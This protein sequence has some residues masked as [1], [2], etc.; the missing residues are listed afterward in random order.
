V[1][2]LKVWISKF[3]SLTELLP[4]CLNDN[5]IFSCSA[6][7]APDSTS[8]KHGLASYP[9][10]TIN[11]LFCYSYT[12]HPIPTWDSR[13]GNGTYSNAHILAGCFILLPKGSRIG[14]ALSFLSQTLLRR[15][16]QSEHQY[17][18]W[19]SFL[20]NYQL[21]RNKTTH[22]GKWSTTKAST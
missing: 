10:E 22:C 1:H 18:V 6:T 11:Y 21:K 7:L 15:E 20:C 5:I 9:I 12:N 16:G 2:G 17:Y 13:D 19:I 8:I 3:S 14:I 4:S